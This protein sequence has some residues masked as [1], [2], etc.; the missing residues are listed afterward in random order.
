MTTPNV[1]VDG[2]KRDQATPAV[3]PAKAGMDPKATGDVAKSPE[4]ETKNISSQDA[5]KALSATTPVA[6]SKS[7]G[8]GN[9]D[10]SAEVAKKMASSQEEKSDDQAERLKS[11]RAAEQED[12]AK[13]ED[14]I[15]TANAENNLF[16]QIAEENKVY[17]DQSRDEHRAMRL[18]EDAEK[19]G[20]P[21]RDAAAKQAVMDQ[22]TPEEGALEDAAKMSQ[23]KT[24]TK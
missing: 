8:S 12:I 9:A 19:I 20:D 24:P 5:A 15:T 16:Y 4:N 6:E 22:N 18:R 10:K 17:S 2:T 14:T 21:T 1:P 11:E 23:G 13:L 3:Q 7:E